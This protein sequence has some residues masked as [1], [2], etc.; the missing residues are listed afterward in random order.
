[1]HCS[2]WGEAVINMSVC[3][4]QHSKDHGLEKEQGWFNGKLESPH[5]AYLEGREP[6][7]WVCAYALKSVAY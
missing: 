5:P 6:T 2:W 3:L 1:M 7:Y 4:K